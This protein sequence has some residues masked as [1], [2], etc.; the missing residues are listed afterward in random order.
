MAALTGDRD[1]HS[2]N[3]CCEGWHQPGQLGSSTIWKGALVV[4]DATNNARPGI[5]A[6]GHTALGRARHRSVNSG[7]SGAVT[8]VVD[9][10][11]FDWNNGTAGDAILSTTPRGT[12]LYVIDDQTVGLTS[13]G[14]TRSV[15]GKLFELDTT[16]G[17]V[18]VEMGLKV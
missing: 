5:T 3:N 14:G 9:E 12:T 2:R 8:V 11:T 16:T 13:G 15:A 10:G 4:V 1:T 17:R 18:W 6:T 7:A